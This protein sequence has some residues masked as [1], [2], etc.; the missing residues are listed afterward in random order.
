[1]KSKVCSKCNEEKTLN[2]FQFRKDRGNYATICKD[3][4][5]TYRRNYYINN[6]EAKIKRQNYRKIWN[7]ENRE[8]RNEFKQNKIHND[9]NFKISHNVRS[10]LNRAL[11]SQNA[12]KSEHTFDLIGCS[13]N[14]LNDWLEFTK[15]YFIPDDYEGKL[16]IDHFKPLTIFDLNDPNQL[17]EACHW[18]NLRYLTLEQNLKKSNK[19]PTPED[20]FKMLVLKKFYVSEVGDTFKLRET[21]NISTTTSSEKSFEGTEL[22]PLPNG[23]NVEV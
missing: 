13:I 18:T 17:K 5:N 21:C 3:C 6:P 19:N 8:K 23:K 11:K 9:E 14:E 12:S 7:R 10:R 22:M 1:M 15:P 2:R 20:K 16:H 4:Q